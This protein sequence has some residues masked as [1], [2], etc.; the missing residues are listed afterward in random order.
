MIASAGGLQG[1]SPQR[2]AAL[3]QSSVLHS[4][5]LVLVACDSLAGGPSQATGFRRAGREG[6]GAD[7]AFPAFF[8]VFFTFRIWRHVCRN[9]RRKQTPRMRRQKQ[10]MDLPASKAGRTPEGCWKGLIASGSVRPVGSRDRILYGPT[11]VGLPM[12]RPIVPIRNILSR[13]TH[14]PQGGRAGRRIQAQLE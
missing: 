5:S 8:E 13:Q 3:F 2:S 1:A 11:A 4:V 9:G 14:F 10:V 12:K 7:L 6:E